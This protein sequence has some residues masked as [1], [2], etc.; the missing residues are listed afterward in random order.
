MVN[1]DKYSFKSNMKYCHV[2]L[3]KLHKTNISVQKFHYRKIPSYNKH[4]IHMQ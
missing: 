3:I 1:M 4:L 2:P